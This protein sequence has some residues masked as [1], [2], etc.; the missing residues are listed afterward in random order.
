MIEVLTPLSAQIQL[1][2]FRND[3]HNFTA[4]EV[5]DKKQPPKRKKKERKRKITCKRMEK[6][7]DETGVRR[8]KKLSYNSVFLQSPNLQELPD[9]ILAPFLCSKNKHGTESTCRL[10][11]MCPGDAEFSFISIESPTR[12]INKILNTPKNEEGTTTG[13]YP[14][15]G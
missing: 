4:K 6:A 5:Q 14:G 8:A 1:I 10:K 12:G 2:H 3:L 9:E 7:P 15:M 11:R 13:G